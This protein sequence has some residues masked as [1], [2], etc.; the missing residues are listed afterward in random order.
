MPSAAAARY[1]GPPPRWRFATDG[2]WSCAAGPP[3]GVTLRWVEV[4]ERCPLDGVEPLSWLVLATHAVA[5]SADEGRSRD[6]RQS[7]AVGGAVEKLVA[8]AAQAGSGHDRQPASLV[9]TPSEIDGLVARQ[10]RFNGKTRFQAN[11][12]PRASLDWVP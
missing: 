6:K 2:R 11:P 4:V 10:Q 1:A 5:T 12:Y 9:I 3:D 7:A 8:I